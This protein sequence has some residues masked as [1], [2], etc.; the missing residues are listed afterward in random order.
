MPEA[1][2][3]HIA[4]NYTIIGI[5]AEM[6]QL[7]VARIIA[8]SIAAN[9]ISKILF[10]APPPFCMIL[11]LTLLLY[12]TGGAN[13]KGVKIMAEKK[14]IV[15]TIR[16]APS[17]HDYI[18]FQIGSNFS[19][20]FEHLVLETRDGEISRR[21]MLAFYD[22]RLKAKEAQL[23]EVNVRLQTLDKIVQSLQW[24]SRNVDGL[25]ETTKRFVLQDTEPPPAAA[26]KVS[27]S[28]LFPA[29]FQSRSGAFTAA[30]AFT[31]STAVF[32]EVPVS[33]G[34]SRGTWNTAG[35]VATED[36]PRKPLD[37]LKVP[38]LSP[39]G[40]H[41][42]CFPAALTA[43]ESPLRGLGGSRGQGAV[44]LVGYWGNAPRS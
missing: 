7:V 12:Q 18:N 30:L 16:M 36:M 39:A 42:T 40:E 20:K 33:G 23:H 29:F 11:T 34:L 17:V 5:I 32:S 44:S 4:G 3:L 24:I 28:P 14:S 26:A 37:S 31:P 8:Y 21:E 15:K 38:T 27:Y 1:C 19:D 25:V 41:G 9:K 10:M 43:S 2:L 6:N 35:S 22:N 13:F